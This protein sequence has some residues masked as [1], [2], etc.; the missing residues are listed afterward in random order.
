MI[1][2]VIIIVAV[3]S[4]KARKPVLGSNMLFVILLQ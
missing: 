2:I 3:M 1:C 4:L